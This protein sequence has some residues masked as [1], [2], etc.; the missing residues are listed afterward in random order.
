MK[1]LKS[2]IWTHIDELDVRRSSIETMGSRRSKGSRGDV[3]TDM[4]DM[5]V[6]E[7]VLLFFIIVDYS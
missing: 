2:D 6:G 4:E 1:R 7:R 5:S 3:L